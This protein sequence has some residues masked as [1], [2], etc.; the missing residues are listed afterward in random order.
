MVIPTVMFYSKKLNS[1]GEDGS[2]K[3]IQDEIKDTVQKSNADE[4]KNG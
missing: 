2:G 1:K 4:V 3:Y